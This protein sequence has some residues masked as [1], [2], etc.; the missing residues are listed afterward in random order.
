MMIGLTLYEK[1]QLSAD[2]SGG[3]PAALD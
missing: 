3:A 2:G 1:Q